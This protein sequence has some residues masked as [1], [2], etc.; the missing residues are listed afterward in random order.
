M[1]EF[2]SVVKNPA[3]KCKIANDILGLRTSFIYNLE[4]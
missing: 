2:R 3:Y 4:M 1:R